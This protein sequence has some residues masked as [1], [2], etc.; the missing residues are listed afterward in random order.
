MALKEENRRLMQKLKK[1]ETTQLKNNANYINT[2][3]YNRLRS[4]SFTHI[5][6]LDSLEKKI[7]PPTRKDIGVMCGVLTRHIGVGHQ[8]ANMKTVSTA[9]TLSGKEID[10]T[11]DKWL[12]EKIKFMNNQN[13]LNSYD[14]FKL[15]KTTQTPILNKEQKEIGVQT[16][17]QQKIDKINNYT[18]TYSDSR[19]FNT[20]NICVQTIPT[21]LIDFSAQKVVEC[22]SIGCSDDTINQV[23]C[24]KCN[25]FKR[26]VGVGPDNN[27]NPLI[28]P[29]NLSSLT[30]P[31][32]KSF[33]LGGD[34]LNLSTKNRTV[35]CQYE[36]FDKISRGIQSE[37][38]KTHSK[39]CQHESKCAEKNT[40]CEKLHL[41]SKLIDTKD[42]IKRKNVECEAKEII[43]RTQTKDIG[44]NTTNLIQICNKCM[45]KDSKDDL[46]VKK[47]ENPTPSR[48][49]R[50][51]IPTT[52][53]EVRKFRRQDTYTKIYST[54]ESKSPVSPVPR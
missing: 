48:I 10:S 15:T 2:F 27:D 26:S 38:T 22:Y 16:K 9:T 43:Q 39:Y 14:K 34:K 6:D 53:V 7:T 36:P 31:R 41:A 40:Q 13:L 5:D 52:P 46:D 24:E 20:K 18:Q 29:I 25:A 28:N 45:E 30:M 12:N 1:D 47:D 4:H 51:Q 21:R 17:H 35:A 54:P 44:C 23:I 19:K 50:P 8:A 33:N 49:P 42:L 3:P 37:K 11:T 32:S